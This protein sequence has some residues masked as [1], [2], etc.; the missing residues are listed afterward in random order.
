MQVDRG[1]PRPGGKTAA[2]RDTVAAAM[3]H[4]RASWGTMRA[5]SNLL[6]VDLA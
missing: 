6:L 5:A 4:E 2:G 3:Q 1:H